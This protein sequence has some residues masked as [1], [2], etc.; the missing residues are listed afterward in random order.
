MRKNS[1]F[2]PTN[3]GL[4]LFLFLAVASS[5]FAQTPL[6]QNVYNRK[7][8]SLNGNWKYVIDPYETGYRNHRNW[9]PFDQMEST[10]NSAKPYYTDKV[11]TERWDRVE[12]NFN[13]SAEIKVPGDWN[14]QDRILLYYEGSLWYRT[15]FDYT[16]GDNNRLFIYFGAANYQTDVYVNGQ[17]VGQHLGGFDPFNFD[18]TDVVKPKD[19]SLMVRV[20]NRREKHRVPNYTTDWWNYGGITRDV[21]LVE[22]PSTY[23]QDYL[24]QL[25]KD[26]PKNIKGYVQLAGNSLKTNVSINIPEAK[27]NFSATTDQTGRVYFDIPAKKIKKWYPKRPKLYNV[28]IQADID[29]LDDQ[30]GFRTIEAKGPDILLN[31]KSIF[32]RGI[33]LHE[34]NPIKIGRARSIEDAKMQMGWAK[35]LNCNFIRLAHYPHNENM[36]RLADKLGLLLWE[37]IPVYWGI[38]YENPEAFSQAKSQ[39]ETMVHRDKNR[40]SV[41]VWS[42]ANETPDTESR[43][44]FLRQLKKIATNIDNTRFISAAL[45]RNE[46]DVQDVVKIPDPFAEDVDMLACNEYIG[47]YSGLPEKCDK[48]TWQ[49]PVD[50]PFFVSE[51]GGGALYNHHG[52]KLTRW[53]EEYQEYLYQEQIKMLKKISTLRGMTPW[54]LA[55]FRSPRRNL[56]IIQDG[57]NRK[58]L[59]SDGGFKKKAF[60]VLK[61][62]YDEMEKKY[63]YQIKD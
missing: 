19:N 39:L 12:Y 44:E 17:K 8:T 42:V 56:P 26:N 34:E 4:L 50:K 59:I 35:E 40:A 24:I 29:T 53:T 62:Y 30:I 36:P 37:E 3:K 51:F 23:I 45:E 15:K 47:W 1:T 20:D 58:G 46:K 32:L 10:R 54:I 28:K 38:D 13:T 49:L 5:V 55:D 60:Y 27:I 6:L 33:S 14:S 31:G 41:I 9:K 22:V 48:V 57:W 21:K 18:I 61:A 7:S 43:L 25:D 52:D 11:I 2:C 63:A 16:I